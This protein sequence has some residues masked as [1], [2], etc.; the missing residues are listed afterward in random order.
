MT[1]VPDA[2]LDPFRADAA[3]MAGTA[4][5]TDFAF[6]DQFEPAILAFKP[7]MF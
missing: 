3:I 2:L 1:N 7:A 4:L 5:P 6:A